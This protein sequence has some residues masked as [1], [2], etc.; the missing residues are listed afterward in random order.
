M[1]FD[2]LP[3]ASCLRPCL[4]ATHPFAHKSACD[5]GPGFWVRNL[6]GSTDGRRESYLLSTD[7]TSRA[8]R[9]LVLAAAFLCTMPLPATLSMIFIASTKAF[10]AFPPS[11][12]E[13]AVRTFLMKVRIV[14]L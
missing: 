9:D 8:S 11:P 13:A 2:G 3:P 14:D 10:L 7:C 4:E 5:S 6:V 1:M 12:C